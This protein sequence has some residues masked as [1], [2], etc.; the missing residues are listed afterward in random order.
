LSTDHRLMIE[1]LKEIFIGI[2][3][4]AKLIKPKRIVFALEENK[5]EEKKQINFYI[6]TRKF[7]LPK[8]E[9]IILKTAYPQ[10]G[11]KQLIY[12]VTKQK[13]PGG[14]LP[15]DIGCLVHNVATCFAIYEAVYLNKPLIERLVSFCGDSLVKPKN[16]WIKI[17]TTLQELFDQKIL[18]F[19]NEPKKIIS[20]GPMM[21]ITLNNLDYPILKG[22][23]GFLFLRDHV[24][25]IKESEC[26]RCARCIDVC[27]M[28]LLP[29]EYVKRVKNEEYDNLLDLNINDCIEC[30]CCAY[31]CPA[32]IPIVHYIKTGKVYVPKN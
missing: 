14:K 10:G 4:I 17:G 28:D 27:P 12:A 7:K 20:G 18:E 13:V 19:K 22:N 26:I 31:I 21:G 29:Q 24:T 3:I 5:T 15:L 30:G 32:Q 2:E 11:E 6:N 9:L 25:E 23:G 16:I 8:T 1:N